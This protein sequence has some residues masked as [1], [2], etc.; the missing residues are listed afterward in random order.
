MRPATRSSPR[1][2]DVDVK[3]ALPDEPWEVDGEDRVDMVTGSGSTPSRHG[4]SPKRWART[5]WW[6]ANTTTARSTC[7]LGVSSFASIRSWVLG[8]SDHATILEPDGVP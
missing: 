3:A 2:I 8:L 4:A 5:R 1:A 6:S 7:A